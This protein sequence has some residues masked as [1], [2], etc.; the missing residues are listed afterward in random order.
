MF[1]DFLVVIVQDLYRKSKLLD[2]KGAKID[3][4]FELSLNHVSSTN[5][6]NKYYIRIIF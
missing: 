5:N 1:L 4:A 6:D 2:H 3:G